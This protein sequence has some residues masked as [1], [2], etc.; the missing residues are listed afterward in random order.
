LSELTRFALF[1]TLRDKKRFAL[2]L[3]TTAPANQVIDHQP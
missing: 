3:S 1:P 2:F